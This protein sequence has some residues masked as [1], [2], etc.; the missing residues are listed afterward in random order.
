MMNTHTHARARTHT[1][2]HKQAHMPRQ[3]L[4][5]THTVGYSLVMCVKVGREEGGAG[6]GGQRKGRLL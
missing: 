6:G 3:S 4:P 1:R 5:H 2:A